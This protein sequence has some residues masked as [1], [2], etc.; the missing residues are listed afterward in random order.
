MINWIWMGLIALAVVSA[1]FTG[2]MG[3]LGTAAFDAGKTAVQLSI[4]LIGIMALWLGLMKIAEEAGLVQLLA[5]IVRPVLARLF[6]DV[7]KDHPALGSMTA[8]FAA[9]MLGLGNAATPLG[10]KA[11]QDLQELNSNKE[12]ATNAMVTFV[13][14]HATSVTIIPATIIGLRSAAGALNPA[15]IIL[16]S[17]IASSIGMVVSVTVA[18]LLERRYNNRRRVA[19]A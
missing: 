7:P 11:M 14:I 5:R 1:V 19:D 18:K 13:A 9:N 10:L 17:L 6:P 8:N 15:S 4:G 12:T 16:P 3:D 2:K